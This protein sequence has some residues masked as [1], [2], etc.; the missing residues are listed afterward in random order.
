MQVQNTLIA[1]GLTAIAGS[2]VALGAPQYSLQYVETQLT[3]TDA[4]LTDTGLALQLYGQHF[5]VVERK[6]KDRQH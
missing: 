3:V 6:A 1:L 2:S 4:R 5:C